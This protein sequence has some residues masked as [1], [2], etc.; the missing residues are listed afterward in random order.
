MKLIAGLALFVCVGMFGSHPFLLPDGTLLEE[1]V[2][3]LCA[4]ILHVDFTTTSEAIYVEIST[5]SPPF[6]LFVP[7]YLT[8]HYD[9]DLRSTLIPGSTITFKIRSKDAEILYAGKGLPIYSLSA[10]GKSVFTLAEH[11]AYW[12]IHVQPMYMISARIGGIAFAVLVFCLFSIW[13]IHKI[14]WKNWP[15]V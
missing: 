1:E 5:A 13:R 14:L 3:E 8:E 11:N 4:D 2:L 12:R 6:T 10:G 15:K 7:P 9:A